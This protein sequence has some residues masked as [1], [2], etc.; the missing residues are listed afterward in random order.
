M[1]TFEQ[2]INESSFAPASTKDV[3]RAA[4]IVVDALKKIHPEEGSFEVQ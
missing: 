2:F 4:K 1:K 3:Q